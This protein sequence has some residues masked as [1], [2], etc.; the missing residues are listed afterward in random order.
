MYSKQAPLRALLFSLS[1]VFTV[2]LIPAVGEDAPAPQQIKAQMKYIMA[3]DDLEDESTIT[4]IQSIIALGDSAYPVLLELLDETEEAVGISHILGVLVAGE[5]DKQIAIDATKKLLQRNQANTSAELRI[6]AVNTL[7]KI[8]ST[9]DAGALIPLIGD[10]S[11]FVRVNVMRALAKLG[12]ANELAP[13]EQHLA[14]RTAQASQDD[15]R[16][17]LSFQEGQKA[18]ESIKRRLAENT[19]Q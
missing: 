11:E 19:T 6:L 8:G 12:T 15:L 14:M 4:N 13:I 3:L 2:L 5:G 7:A 1:F 17:D 16:M 9:N 18:V 10:S